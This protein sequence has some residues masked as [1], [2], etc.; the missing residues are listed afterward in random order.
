MSKKRLIIGITGA[1][2]SC[3]GVYALRLLRELPEWETHLVMTR[4]AELTIKTELTEPV[5]YVTSLADYL[6]NEDDVSASISS[7]SFQAEGMLIAPCSM[8]TVSGIA[9]GFSDNLLLRAADVTIKEHR[10][11]VILPREA[12]M[13]T[14]H[15]R[16]LLTLA[17]LGVTIFPPVPAF[18]HNPENIEDIVKHIIGR[19]LSYFNISNEG[20]YKSWQGVK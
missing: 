5:H 6:H 14:I 9:N 16:N 4:N 2:G 15:L 7:G 20:L 8:K 3:F 1:S 18:Y 10:P 11:L 13:S 12:P 19:S 17:E